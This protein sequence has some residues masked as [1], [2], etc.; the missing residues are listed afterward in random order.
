M[1][2]RTV[3]SCRT[4]YAIKQS[5]KAVHMINR[6]TILA[7]TIFLAIVSACGNKN[8]EADSIDI[9]SL[10]DSSQHNIIDH[11]SVL[12]KDKSTAIE[13]VEPI[14]FS[15][16]GKENIIGQRP[17]KA[18]LE[19]SLWVVR[20]TLPEGYVGGTFLVIVDSRTMEI[21]R[22]THGK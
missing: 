22:L 7:L 1:A 13:V 5:V 17:Y 20:G 12:I 2:I 9:E 4:L 6:H 8:D 16:Y 3:R 21:I 15:I 14:L 19:D 11:K 18:K 10:T